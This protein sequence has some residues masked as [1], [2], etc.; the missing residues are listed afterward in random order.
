MCEWNHDKGMA[1]NA[2]VVPLPDWCDTGKQNRTVCID[3][4]IL[5]III[6]L[7]NNGIETLSNCCGHDKGFGKPSIVFPSEYTKARMEH[8]KRLIRGVD[9]RGFELSQWKRIT[10]KWKRITTKEW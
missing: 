4:C 6:H 5:H 8:I 7:W 1:S 9:N 10:T 3:K 2:V